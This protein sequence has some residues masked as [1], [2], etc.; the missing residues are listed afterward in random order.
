M[1]KTYKIAHDFAIR[2][3]VPTFDV[4]Q[5]E[6]VDVELTLTANGLP[7]PIPDGAGAELR[8]RRP[9]GRAKIHDGAEQENLFRILGNTVSLSVPAEMIQEAGLI[10]MQIV[11]KREESCIY[12][13]QWKFACH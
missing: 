4:Q 2:K 9:S 6:E 10:S 11:I 8:S 13:A 3:V 12:A 7:W 5:G 1:K